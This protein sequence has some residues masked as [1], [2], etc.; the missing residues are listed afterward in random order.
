MQL[1]IIIKM[2]EED[3]II[4]LCQVISTWVT[5]RGEAYA[6]REKGVFKH[7]DDEVKKWIKELEK[8]IKSE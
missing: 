3:R 6:R 7:C 2:T 1:K 5:K 8:R 4:H